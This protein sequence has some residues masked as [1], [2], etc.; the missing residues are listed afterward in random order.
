MPFLNL[1]LADFYDKM[2][3]D[4]DKMLIG[5]RIIHSPSV[6]MYNFKYDI[7]IWMIEYALKH[8]E[9]AEK[10]RDLVVKLYCLEKENGFSGQD[11]LEMYGELY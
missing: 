2:T 10:V 1:D 5:W 3:L 4:A 11:I 8:H 6:I 7:L 9:Y